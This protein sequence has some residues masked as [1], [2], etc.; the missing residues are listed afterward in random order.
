M[1]ADKR[2]TGHSSTH[3]RK[4]AR[5]RAACN[6]CNF[7]KVKCSGEK[8]GCSRCISIQAECIY[9]E[10]RVGR[11][12]GTRK[13]K[14]QTEQSHSHSSA[15]LHSQAN[16]IHVG[17]DEDGRPKTSDRA[18]PAVNIA[19]PIQRHAISAAIHPTIEEWPLEEWTWENDNLL[20]LED[21][22]LSM[23]EIH[24]PRT[25]SSVS[26]TMNDS[27]MFLCDSLSSCTSLPSTNSNPMDSTKNPKP[28]ESIP[29]SNG[30]LV[31]PTCS[32]HPAISTPAP[33]AH[34]MTYD[35]VSS[36]KLRAN[37]RLES[38]CILALTNM[39]TTLE[40]YLLDGL[41]V[42]DLIISTSRSMAQGLRKIMAYHLLETAARGASA[43]TQHDKDKKQS[44]GST[45]SASSRT[46]VPADDADDAEFSGP[47]FGNFGTWSVLNDEEQWSWRMY[48]ISK[49]CKNIEEMVA[50]LSV[51]ASIGPKGATGPPLSLEAAPLPLDARSLFTGLLKKLRDLGERASSGGTVP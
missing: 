1:N 18:D 32:T 15:C 16:S 26:S 10:S 47:Q 40:R 19:S 43:P 36:E 41:A 31:N 34:S 49:E 33:A 21:T 8:T 13:K 38:K 2:I 24:V 4:P 46:G 50:Q 9:T 22:V 25:I 44:S 14:K 27:D 48:A 35:A 17:G 23:N 51:L 3:Q 12:Q 30:G 7:A 28:L 37:A 39:A 5:L 20:T 29:T 6:Q 42:L 11:V 45:S